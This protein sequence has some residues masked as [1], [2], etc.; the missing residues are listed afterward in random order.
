MRSRMARHSGSDDGAYV[1]EFD[2]RTQQQRLADAADAQRFQQYFKSGTFTELPPIHGEPTTCAFD[3]G[4]ILTVRTVERVG[5]LGH[6]IAALPPLEWLTHEIMGAT[7]IVH[8]Q[9]RGEYQRSSVVGNVTAALAT[10]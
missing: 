1:A 4:G 9:L 7:M 10:D 6:L 3:V 8:V 5:A 2:V